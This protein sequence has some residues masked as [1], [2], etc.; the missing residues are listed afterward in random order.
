MTVNTNGP[1]VLVAHEAPPTPNL[2]ENPPAPAET[3]VV[4]S[5][6]AQKSLTFVLAGFGP[7][8]RHHSA[9]LF[10]PRRARVE[11][12]GDAKTGSGE[13]KVQYVSIQGL[14]LP[15]DDPDGKVW[16]VSDVYTDLD[17]LTLR[18][19]L[20]DLGDTLIQRAREA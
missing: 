11:L 14:T 9:D 10:I 8:R 16:N 7:I 6:F 15:G 20:G 4:E 5:L 12:R 13:L 19:R 18:A 2:H 3:I 17:L 1:R